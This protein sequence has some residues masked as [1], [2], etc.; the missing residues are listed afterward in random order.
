MR[1]GNAHLAQ[2]QEHAL[3]AVLAPWQREFPGLG[4][5]ALLP[6]AEKEQLP[7][8]QAVCR[9]LDIPLFGGIFPAL[10][11]A[12]GFMTEGVWLLRLDQWGPA[13]LVAGLDPAAARPAQQIVDAVQPLLAACPASQA[14]P[15]LYL[16]FDG[17]I[18]NIASILDD[19][20][21]TL[22][23][24]VAYAG[25]NA[26]SETFAPMPCLFDREQTV[27]GGV[28]CLLLPDNG[29]TVLEHAY[30]AGERVMS[31]TSTAGNRIN[32]IDWR[33]AFEVYRAM[34][35]Q[36]YGVDLTPTNFYEHA[37]HF[38][39]GILRA[40]AEVVV[41]IP[42]GLTE[43]G[44]VYCVGEVPENAMLVLLRAPSAD[45][46]GCVDKLAQA[47]APLHDQLAGQTLLTFYCA[48]R[49]MH[50]GQAAVDEIGQ[51][52][53]RLAPVVLAGALSLGE[54]GG[55]RS[56]DYPM[57]HNAALVCTPWGQ[58]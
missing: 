6:E 22:A 54:I 14:K 10:L 19:L 3:R 26:G 28:A 5:L 9:E 31:A 50:L 56:W 42:V 46:A 2:L 49:R 18:P 24:R 15:T 57:F 33:P 53:G 40:N 55:S 16:L 36:S 11:T 20:Y 52:A 4:V 17:L 35:R 45:A 38:P 34:V 30:P 8:L 25:A 1:I 37:V 32:Q 58:A 48:G 51:L 12:R 13:L 43:D 7:L 21:L 41:R 27:A 23:D 44:A 29:G 39:L 47:L